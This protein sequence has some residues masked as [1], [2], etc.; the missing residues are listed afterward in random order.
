M[1]PLG[2][3]PCRRSDVKGRS[4]SV[5]KKDGQPWWMDELSVF[6]NKKSARQK[7]K[8]RLLKIKKSEV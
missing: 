6:E 2:Q 3:K 4:N 8:A 7:E 1:K 5:K